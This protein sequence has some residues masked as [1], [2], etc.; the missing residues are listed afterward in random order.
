MY[1]KLQ[2]P[3]G[4][5]RR[6][7]DYYAISNGLTLE[8]DFEYAHEKVL[9]DRANDSEYSFRTRYSEPIYTYFA[10][11]K[12]R[13]SANICALGAAVAQGELSVSKVMEILRGHSRDVDGRNSVASVCMHAGGLIGDQTTGAYIAAL[14][15]AYGYYY[16]TGASLPCMSVFKPLLSYAVAG[17]CTDKG[18]PYWKERERLTRYFLAGMADIG[19]FR[20]RRAVLESNTISQMENIKSSKDLAAIVVEATVAEQALVDEFLLPLKGKPYEFSLGKGSYRKY[21]TKNTNKLIEELR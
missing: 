6:V 18:V 15:K 4:R 14:G 21:W 9:A 20:A 12:A 3:T 11:S 19:A 10:H 8:G 2:A 5:E 13:R 1:L 16:A 17:D 7:E